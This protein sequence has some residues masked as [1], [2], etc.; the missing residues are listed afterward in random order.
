MTYFTFL[1]IF[2]GI[3]LA[4]LG[5]L[6]LRDK[7]WGQRLPASLTSWPATVVVGAHVVVAVL[8]TTPWDN[9][10]VATGVWWYDPELVFG[11]VLGWVPLEEYTFFV[12]QTIMTS[13]WL[14]WLAPRSAPASLM[15]AG[16]SRLRIV[17]AL[18]LS[19]AWTI[20]VWLWAAAD[21]RWTYL[22]LE[23]VWALPP[24][25]LQLAFGA[26]I[27]WHYR[28]LVLW[29]LI[30]ATLY[31]ALADTVAIAS[32]TWT[33]DPNQSTG[34]LVGS[35]PIEEAIFFLATNTLVVFGV[36]LVSARESQQRVEL[37]K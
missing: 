11:I 29:A 13:L 15:V 12:A 8:Y 35:L 19:V 18:L 3:P 14:L 1:L 27:L 36:V 21:A 22:A 33:I 25:I 23:L 5:V 26:D 7:R 6:L 24:I 10:L 32:G 30:P 4:I 20:S 34:L 17:G 31:L 2:L 16:C 9:Y 37:P 28:R